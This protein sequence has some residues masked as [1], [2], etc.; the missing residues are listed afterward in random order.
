MA[1]EEPR[2]PKPLGFYVRDTVSGTRLLSIS[3]LGRRYT[4]NFI[5]ADVRAPLLGAD[6]LAHFGLA[7]DVGHKR[8]LDTDSRQSLPLAPG[9]SVPTICSVAPHQYA[10]LLKE[11]PDVFK[12]ELCQVPAAPAKHGIYHHIKTKGPP[13]HTKFWRLPPRRLQEARDTFARM[14]RMGICKKASS[15]WASPLHMVQK[16][17]H[18]WRPCGNYRRLNLSTE[19]DHYPLSKHTGSHG[20]L[21][22]GQNIL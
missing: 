8:L 7:V 9:P 1:A 20:L 4:W 21:S 6:F 13:T 14:E 22:Q 2:S 5:I 12:P 18:S 15:Q 17:E 16:P 11:F 3:I 19:P 10:K